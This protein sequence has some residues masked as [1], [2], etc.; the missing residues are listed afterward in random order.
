MSIRQF[1]LC[2]EAAAVTGHL[3]WGRLSAQARVTGQQYDISAF[4]R[5]ME[6]LYDILHRVSRP[7]HRRGVLAAD[8]EFLAR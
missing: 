8:L 4:V 5:K 2:F 7:T 3:P 6:R 1:S